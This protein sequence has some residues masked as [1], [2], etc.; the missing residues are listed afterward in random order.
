M[1]VK[2]MLAFITENSE[3]FVDAVLRH[4]LICAITLALSAAIGIPLGYC[5]AKNARLAG[6]VITLINCI[7]M[8][9]VIAAFFILVPIMGMGMPPAIFVLFFYGLYTIVISTQSG[10]NNVHAAVVESARG[11][12]MNGWQICVEVELPLARPMIINGVRIATVEI[13]AGATIASYIS[14]GGLGDIILWGMSNM[15]YSITFAGGCVVILIVIVCDMALAALQK[16]SSH[17]M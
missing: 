14:A 4:L 6:P 17:Y 13:V 11:M 10:V 3:L 16:L 2:N 5:L 12:G 15:D 1:F 9:P 7:R 8:I